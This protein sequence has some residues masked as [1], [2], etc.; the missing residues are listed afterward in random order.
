MTEIVIVPAWKRPAFLLATLRR[1]AE[2]D[3]SRV[4]FWI[5]LDRGHSKEVAQVARQFAARVGPRVR[6]LGKYHYYRGNSFNVLATYREALKY[7]PEIIHLVEEDV[8]VGVDYFDFHRSAHK[9]APGVFAVSA[10][11]NQN[12]ADDPAPDADAI[13]LNHQYQSVGVSFRPNMLTMI[14]PHLTEMYFKEPVKYCRRKFP[15]TRIPVA[16]AEQ[17]GLLNRIAE[18]A[19]LPVAYPTRPRAYHAGFFGYHRKGAALH[20]TIEHQADSLLMMT[21]ADLNA[22]AFSYPDHQAVDLDAYT[23][24]V[25][26]VISWPDQH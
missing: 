18:A 12:Y 14:L 3:D 4:H 26:R 13:Y 23:G 10:C 16:N 11:R 21:T 9:L 5:A 25:T 17:D 20:G 15:K 2:A 24:D 19:G 6:L 7:E 22:A 1:L 8:F